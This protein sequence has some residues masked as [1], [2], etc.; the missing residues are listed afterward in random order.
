[1]EKEREENREASVIREKDEG[2]EQLKKS[3]KRNSKV[4]LMKG[5]AAMAVIAAVFYV[6][7]FLS[8][9]AQ[10]TTTAVVNI[11]KE[12]STD[13]EVVGSTTKGKTIDILEAVKDSSGNVWY[14]VSIADGGYGYIRSDYVQ[15]SDTIEVTSTASGTST[16]TGSTTKPADTVPTSI[17]ERQ[18]VIQSSDKDVNVRSGAS[19]QHDVV[20]SLPGGTTVTLIGE[21]TDSS[22]NKWYQLTCEYNGKT[23]EGYV[24]SDLIDET[25]STQVDDTEAVEGEEAEG[26]QGEDGED[27]SEESGQDTSVQEETEAHNDYAVAYVESETGEGDYYLYDYTTGVGTQTSITKLKNLLAI[28]SSEEDANKLISQV[29]NEKII[30]IILAVVIVI[31]FIVL[32]VLLFKLREFYYEYEEEEEE[33]EEEP[34]PVKKRSRKRAEEEEAPLPAKKKKS[35]SLK[36]EEK[37]VKAAK[38]Q[39]K[40]REDKE[41]YAAEMKE[42]AK[43]PATRRPQ[44]FLIDDDEFEF[45]FLN[46]DDKDL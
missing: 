30:I 46:M 16:S 7:A 34:V 19:T 42:P 18:A 25:E 21:A 39:T 12:A 45:E 41:L 15:T 20:T 38:Q 14:K 11:R 4:S 17:G 13:S 40:S 32:T 28:V 37:P 24:R 36:T 23:I 29:Q 22:G 10:G 1:M 3:S 27:T 8:Q 35:T 33:E 44:N 9:A 6:T 43:K 5:I 2:E 26:T 31:M